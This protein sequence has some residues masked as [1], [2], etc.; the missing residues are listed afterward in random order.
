[1]A[2]S[3]RRQ[4][5][6]EARRQAILDAAERLIGE[7]GLWATTMEDVAAEAE[8]SKGTLYLYF[9]NRDAL[10]AALAE[11]TIS[12]GMAELQQA[13]G[14]AS[15]G[16]DRLRAALGFFG[17]FIPA[18]PHLFRMA[19]SWMITG[20]QCPSDTPDLVEYRQRVGGVVGV[21]VEAIERGQRDGTIRTDLDP[22]L[23][24]V[25]LWAG[26]LGTF[27]AQQNRDDLFQRLP[28]QIDADGLVPLYVDNMLRAVHTPA[29]VGS[30][31]PEP[32]E[33]AKG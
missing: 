6:R 3:H 7:R 23:L 25:Q 17:R 20:I 32:P 13:V 1:M 16:F 14:S 27:L 31:P 5:E 33:E 24:A 19:V 12:A 26:M 8:L 15:T 28:F 29:S 21:V 4:R 18:R 11:R 30:T 10:C 9:E 2:V 22:R